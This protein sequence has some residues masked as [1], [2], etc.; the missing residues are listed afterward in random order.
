MWTAVL[1]RVLRRPQLSA[2]VSGGILVAL[3]LPALGMHTASAGIDAIPKDNAGHQDVRP[4]HRRVP[5]REGRAGVVVKADDVTKPEVAG[6]IQQL[7]ARAAGTKTAI[8]TTDVEI[9]KD[10]TVAQV[11][12]PIAGKGTDDPSMAALAKIRDDLVP[13]TVGKVRGVEAVVGGDTA[14]TKDYNDL[15]K[16]NAPIVF[17]FVLGLAFLLLLATFRSL[18]IP[19][20]AIVLNLLS[21]GAAYGVLVLV[22]QD[23]HG[24]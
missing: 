5:R 24:E 18:V 15:V 11:T 16:A 1:D 8:D 7:E 9:S 10:K 20:K 2:V 12:I 3:A 22:F 14:I 21:V 13:A 4:H 6:A 17:A 19:I 23:G